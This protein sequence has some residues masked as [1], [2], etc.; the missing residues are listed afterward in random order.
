M[1]LRRRVF[2]THRRPGKLTGDFTNYWLDIRR[3]RIT[4]PIDPLDR[5]FTVLEKCNMKV[6][7]PSATFGWAM[8]PI[9]SNSDAV[10]RLSVRL[11]TPAVVSRIVIDWELSGLGSAWVEVERVVFA[12]ISLPFSS[13][14]IEDGSGTR[15][16]AGRRELVCTKMQDALQG[17]Q[18][19]LYLRIH[20]NTPGKP[21][22]LVL[23]QCAV[24]L[25]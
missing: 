25:Y 12:G 4:V 9:I 11:T 18:F 14:L 16:G 6:S 24:H 22:G 13:V 20:Y 10:C 21:G 19:E 3:A 17:D 7:N 15:H 2:I 5:S 23:N 1:F 8:E